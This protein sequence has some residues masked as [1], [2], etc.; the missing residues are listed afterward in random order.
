MKQTEHLEQVALMN[1]AEMQSRHTPELKL[2]FAVPNGGKRNKRVA[3]K[4]KAEGVKAGV[5]DLVLPI[6]R[7]GKNC[8]FIEM[9]SPDGRVRPNQIWWQD[10]LEKHGNASIVCYGWESAKTAI[11]GYLEGKR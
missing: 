9:K 6:A 1:W 8:L 11:I 7:H 4:L 3:E 2:L 10:Q 5:P